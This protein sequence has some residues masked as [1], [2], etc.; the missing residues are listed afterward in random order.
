[1]EKNKNIQS[2]KIG[3]AQINLTVGD[4]EGN[5]Q[6]I[7]KYL[8]IAENLG[9]NI[10]SFSELAIT[11]YPPE[12]LLIKPKF[13]EDNLKKL[14]EIAKSVK[15][16]TAI[17][18]FVDN[19]RY[20]RYTEHPA[21][22][23][24]GKDIYNAAAVIYRGMIKGIYRKMLLPNY[25]VFDEKRYFKSGNEPS[26]FKIG[27]I[28]FGINICEDVWEKDGPIKKQAAKGAKL[29]FA[30]NA[31]PYHQGKIKERE[32]V[33]K[34][35]AKN[36]N[37]FVAYTNLIGGQDELVFDGQSMVADNTGKIIARAQAFKEDLLVVK[38]RFTPG[39][40]FDKTDASP[41]LEAL[42]PEAEVYQALILGIR[43]YVIKNGFKSAVIGLSGGIDSSLVAAL[44][45]DALGKENVVAVYMPSR[46]SSLQ[47]KEDAKELAK[48]LGI[49]LMT[50]PIE[51]VFKIYLKIL[52]P[53][54]QSLK[55]D[56]AEENL[57]ARIRGNILMALSNKFGWLVLATGNKSEMSVG[58]ATLYGDMA[59]GFSPT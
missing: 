32:E 38:F 57:Q 11:G 40:S 3:L 37:V 15:D 13:I 23:K 56:V 25:G 45:A 12:D 54:F 43:D 53:Q 31:S 28:N 50:I 6:K 30:I 34:N 24:K 58:Y 1:M 33:I 4:L 2:L 55:P 19:G 41:K 35:Q 20:A 47:S 27:K 22:Y 7:K 51:P 5:S 49:K 8:K 29:I 44:A 16:I 21:H 18:G 36:N 10:I 59:G 17:I 9:I 26:V 46:F 14:K 52:K 42:E 39:L 48:N